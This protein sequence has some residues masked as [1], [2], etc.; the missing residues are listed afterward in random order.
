METKDLSDNRIMF[1]TQMTSP[2]VNIF[3][4]ARCNRLIS[5]SFLSRVVSSLQQQ[6]QPKL[7]PVDVWRQ[8]ILA[9]KSAKTEKSGLSRDWTCVHVHVHRKSIFLP[10]EEVVALALWWLNPKDKPLLPTIPS[11]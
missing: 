10:S 4:L 7:Q 6:Q 3:I 9:K 5:C 2:S 11:L 8:K 1:T